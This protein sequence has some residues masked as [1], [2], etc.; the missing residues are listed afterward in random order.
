MGFDIPVHTTAS[1]GKILPVI[2]PSAILMSALVLTNASSMVESVRRG[3]VEIPFDVTAVVTFPFDDIRKNISIRDTTGAVSMMVKE[4]ATEAPSV[5]MGDQIRAIGRI[6]MSGLYNLS[7]AVC[8]NIKVLAH[9]ILPLP[10]ESSA[11][12]ILDGSR[13]GN[14]K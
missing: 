6:R 7:S 10:L 3:H 8:T 2:P 12:S 5:A 4:T 11:Q 13:P 9:G 1:C 14:F